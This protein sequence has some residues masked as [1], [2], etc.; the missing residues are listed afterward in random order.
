[1]PVRVRPSAPNLST[2]DESLGF[3]LLLALKQRNCLAGFK[4]WHAEVA[5]NL[6]K[7]AAESGEPVS[8]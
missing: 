1:M 2:N 6:A 8:H 5:D 4:H 3:A 7:R